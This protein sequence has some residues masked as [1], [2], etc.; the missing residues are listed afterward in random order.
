[1]NDVLDVVN[2]YNVCK[3]EFFTINLVSCIVYET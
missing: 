2:D 3:V 1:M